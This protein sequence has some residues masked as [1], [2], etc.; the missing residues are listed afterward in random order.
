M[1][2]PAS[3]AAKCREDMVCRMVDLSF[4][5]MYILHIQFCERATSVLYL[6]CFCAPAECEWHKLNYTES[7]IYRRLWPYVCT[8]LNAKA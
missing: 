4:I 5:Y 3:P 8:L 1:E 2:H 6:L 7:L